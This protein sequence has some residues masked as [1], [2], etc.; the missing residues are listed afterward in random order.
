MRPSG[1]DTGRRYPAPPMSRQAA[2]D[3]ENTEFWDTLCGWNLAQRAGIT[4]RGEDD[5]RRF[6]ELYLGFY[7]YLERYVPDD[8]T[9]KKVLE[10]GLG[11]GTLSQLLASRGADLSAAD[12]APGPVAIVRRRLEWLGKASGG[13]APGR[14]PDLPRAGGTVELVYSYQ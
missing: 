10:I 4:G 13:A 6:D 12:I 9:G 1:R 7:P 2:I 8:L 14:A 5:L 11:Y 3:Q